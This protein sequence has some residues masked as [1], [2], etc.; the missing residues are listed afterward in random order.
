[1]FGVVI[2]VG[3]EDDDRIEFEAFGEEGGAEALAMDFTA[4]TPDDVSIFLHGFENR[5]FFRS[6]GMQGFDEASEYFVAATTEFQVLPKVD[7]DVGELLGAWEF[8]EGF[9]F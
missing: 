5:D 7:Q 9:E 8:D 3:I 4:G 2:F 6:S 1:M